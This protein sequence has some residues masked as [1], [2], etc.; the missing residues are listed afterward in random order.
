M[1][2][3]PPLEEDKYAK[4]YKID[5]P[6][7]KFE[8]GVNEIQPIQ[9]SLIKIAEE[10]TKDDVWSEVICWIDQ[11]QLPEK[12]ETR[13]KARKVLVGCSMFNPEVFKMKNGV[14]MFTKAANRNLIGEV[15]WICLQETMIKEV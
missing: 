10:Q 11:G 3:S 5:E 7:I 1:V 6:V 2:E 4:F 14:L 9:R 8:G 13:G 12:T 15:W